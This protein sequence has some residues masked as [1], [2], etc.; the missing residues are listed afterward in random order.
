MLVRVHSK[1]VLISLQ[2]HI[3]TC[4][5]SKKWKR[6]LN[7]HLP[8][9]RRKIC[10]TFLEGHLSLS[11]KLL[12]TYY[13]L[14]QQF[15]KIILHPHESAKYVNKDV[16]SSVCN[17]KKLEIISMPAVCVGTSRGIEN[18]NY[19]HISKRLLAFFTLIFLTMSILWYYNRK[20]VDEN[21]P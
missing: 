5:S 2:V 1:D 12:N 9:P 14:V 13:S 15:Y 21:L 16:V 11:I 20:N 18:Q 6:I 7:S 4:T 10:Q 3:C 19:V 8:L 17:G